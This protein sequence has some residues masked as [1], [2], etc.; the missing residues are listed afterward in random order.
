MN[1]MEIRPI[2][3]AL[4]AEIHGVDAGNMNEETWANIRQAFIDHLVIFLPDQ[5]L[6]PAQFQAWGERFGP[7]MHHPYL[8]PIEGT[9]A[10]HELYKSPDDSGSFGSVWH[11]DLPFFE[12]P[13]RATSLYARIVPDFGGDTL[14][15]NRY[16]AYE[17]LPDPY[18]R[19]LEDTEG[20]YK[21]NSRYE[22]NTQRMRNAMGKIKLDD[23]ATHPLVQIHPLSGR[24]YLMFCPLFI[25]HFTGLSE[26]DSRPLIE[27]LKQ[28][29]TRP[30]FTTRIRWRKNML[31]IWDNWACLHF[32]INDYAGKERHMHRLVVH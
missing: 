14:F 30:E 9:D 29:C 17:S 24:K 28:H 6:K 32:A 21:I 27:Y 31:G 19:L 13:P 8:K 20:I 11:S 25:T 23:G 10:V 3:G 22:R 5:S 7:L 15:A 18:K 4:G 2:A 1:S 26:E 12:T 16:L